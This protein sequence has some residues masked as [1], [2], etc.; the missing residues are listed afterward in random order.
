[1]TF[2]WLFKYIFEAS[3]EGFVKFS[4]EV[5]KINYTDEEFEVIRESEYNIDILVKST[6]HIIVIENKIKSSI[7]GIDEK[8]NIGSKLVQT[9]LSK[10]YKY[11]QK[12]YP[13]KEKKYFIFA[14]NYNHLKLDSYECGEN[15]QLIEYKEIYD[16]F[17]KNKN[18]YKNIK[19]FS[20]FLFALEKHTK[21]ID[22]NHEEI[23]YRRF[24]LAIKRSKSKKS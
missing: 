23:M 2:S 24:C 13:N 11:I 5:L 12:T 17:E 18:L 20:E 1:M 6:N 16:F 4:M 10:Y 7:N 3:K 21:P 15:Y 22:N 19:Y 9:Q 8:H 14:P